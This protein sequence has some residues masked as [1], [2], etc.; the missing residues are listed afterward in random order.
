LDS[1]K[2]ELGLGEQ[3]EEF[4]QPEIDISTTNYQVSFDPSPDDSISDGTLPPDEKQPEFE[5][6]EHMEEVQ[7]PILEQLYTIES[8]GNMLTW[9]DQQIPEPMDEVVDIQA[10]SYDWKMKSIMKRTTKNR[11]LSMDCS[12]IIITEEKLINTE[13]AETFELIKR[14]MEIIYATLDREKRD[15]R[16]L[17]TTLKELEHILHLEKYYQDSTQAT[18]FLRSEL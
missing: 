2:G 8:L 6:S 4:S 18:M 10:I 1:P 5:P 17:A 16:E 13:H 15:E 7:E 12:I 3:Q 11:R 14:G 9:G